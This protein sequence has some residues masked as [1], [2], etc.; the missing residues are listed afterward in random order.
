[1]SLE[2]VRSRLQEALSFHEALLG[3]ADV[4]ATGAEILV[5][6]YRAGNKA[7][8]FGNGGSA[9]DAQHLAAE[10]VGR[11]ARERHAI[12]ALALT[13]NTSALTAVANDYGYEEIFRRQV[14]AHGQPGDVAI[15]ISTSGNSPSVLAGVLEAR[16]RGLVT[17][18]LTGDDGGKLRPIVH[19]C[20]TVPSRE[21]PRI[22]EAHVLIG[23]IW[24]ELV[25][26]ALGDEA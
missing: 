16:E 20:V 21:T 6:A 3:R 8:F 2:H 13:T 15:A 19:H 17:I 5:E 10:L 4:I 1:M 7:L 14:A 12:A 26:K 18:G 9:A 22:Q 24:C 11:Y 23:H 25:E